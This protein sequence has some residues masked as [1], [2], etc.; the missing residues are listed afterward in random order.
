[1][2]TTETSTSVYSLIAEELMADVEINLS[3]NLTAAEDKKPPS[4][5]T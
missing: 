4:D 2:E 5:I 3:G 1:M